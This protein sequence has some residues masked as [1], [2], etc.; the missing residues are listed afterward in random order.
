M[1]IPYEQV[2]LPKLW[3][4]RISRQAL[5]LVASLSWPSAGCIAATVR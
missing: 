5:S 3:S 1:A 2:G 4:S